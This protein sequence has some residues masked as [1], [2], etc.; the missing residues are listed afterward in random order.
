MIKVILSGCC[1]KMGEVVKNT[2]QEKNSLKIVAGI[3]KNNDDSGE[4]PIYDKFN[5]I[6]ENTD[7][8]I[9]F[10]N[11]IILK[12]LLEYSV[13]NKVAAVLA[14]TGYNK[15]DEE[16]VLKA[17]KEIP[18]F[19]SANMS[20]GINVITK[21]LKTT[22]KLLEEDF[23]IEIIESHHKFKQDSPSGTAKL[24]LNVIK[25]NLGKETIEV[26]GREGLST[27]RKENEIGIHAIRGGTI[28][29]EHTILFAG[30]DENIEIKH[31]AMSKKVFG[32]G[33][34]KAAE[35]IVNCEAGIY[36]MDNL[37]S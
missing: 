31:T 30:N 11:R 12:D 5:K 36:S 19:R 6:K 34:V 37:L 4:F 17:S 13:K 10:S 24:L 35:Y 7:V 25:D 21:I 32:L 14:T 23:D 29:G 16:L 20:Y 28:S 2:V 3:D 26:Y 22:V 27:K 1:G 18:I 8:I 15:N 33:A 9:D